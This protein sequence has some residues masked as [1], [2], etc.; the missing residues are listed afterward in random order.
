MKRIYIG[1]KVFTGA[2]PLTE[3][4]IVEDGRFTAVGDS[5]AMVGM[6]AE[7]D[8]VIDLQGRFVCPGFNDSHM[9]LLNY[10]YAMRCCNL[11]EHTD[12]KEALIDGMKEFLADGDFAPGDWIRGR[13]FNQDYFAG[14]KVIPTSADLDRISTEHPVLIVRCC[15]H[16]LVV[17]SKALALLGLDGS[18]PQPDGGHYD[19]DQNG[20][21]T[22]VFRDAAM[23]YVY[24]GVPQPDK[25]AVKEMLLAGM[26]V[27]GS[28]GVTS[29]QTDDF[30]A[31]D[32]VDYETVIAA[33]KELEAEGKMTVRVYEQSHFTNPEGLQ[34]FF[35]KGYNTGWGDQ[36]FK[37]GP[38]KM[39]GDGSLGARTAFM[40]KDYADAP[41]ERGLAIFTQEQFDE[42]VALAHKNGMQVA[43]HAIGDGILDRI[44]LAYEKAF[45]AYPREDHRSGVVHVQ[46][47][48]PE[49]LKKMAELSLHGYIQSIFLD[50]DIRIVADR[51][52]EELASSSYAFGTMGRLGITTSNGTD[53]PVE[54]PDPM[55]GIQ[56][57][58]TRTTVS[59][60]GPY[61]KDEALSLEAALQS[62][63]TGGAYA[64]FEEKEKGQIKA[65]MLADFVILPEDPFRVPAEKLHTLRAEETYL[66]GRRVFAR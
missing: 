33:Y 24:S 13:G 30:C 31:F 21:P 46:I 57:A 41:G 4:F 3:G 26:A 10:G 18:Q 62:Y 45:A 54:M 7:G 58:V 17:N 56:C 25:A 36:Y 50:Y 12:S 1:G 52:G 47:T 55:R 63:T 14:E 66:G 15:G 20:K 8:E 34:E 59:G 5:E 28:Y 9:H 2:L 51:V 53:C 48:R 35:D 39:L 43:I 23:N 27:L 16:C 29:C 38:L 65:G 11:M 6:K 61:C 44:L 37:I 64:S 40:A 49:Q 22:G 42:M 19:T 32:G 60:V